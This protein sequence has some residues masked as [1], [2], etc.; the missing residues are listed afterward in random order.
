[1]AAVRLCLRLEFVSMEDLQ[2][3]GSHSGTLQVS[4]TL[5]VLHSSKLQDFLLGGMGQDELC[6]VAQ[7]SSTWRDSRPG[8]RG[9]MSENP[10]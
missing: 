7:R 9:Q 4:P 5:R 3:W 8:L 2:K 1:M 10:S 6:F